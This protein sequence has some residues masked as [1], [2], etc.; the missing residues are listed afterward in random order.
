[1]TPKSEATVYAVLPPEPDEDTQ[2][3]VVLPVYPNSLRRRCRRCLRHFR[4]GVLVSLSFLAL[5]VSIFLLWPCDPNLQLVR[6]KL[7]HIRVHSSPLSLDLSL[8]LTLRV[9]N[10]DFYS[11]NYDSLSV[12]IGYRGKELG[13]VDSS[14][15]NVKARGSSYVN[16]TLML[17]GFRVLHDLIYLIEDVAAGSVPFD[18]VSKVEGQLGL[19]FFSIPIQAIVSCEIYVNPKNQTII[20]Q[21]CYPE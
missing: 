20:R 7:N 21:N 8:C 18:T 19:L 11:L 12:S 2:N 6:V 5:S 13:F 15:G 9:R 17:D 3:Y 14:G 10:R 1:M 4:R 16:A